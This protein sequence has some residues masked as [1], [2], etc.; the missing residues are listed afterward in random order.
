MIHH[1]NKQLYEKS[2][3]LLLIRVGAGSVFFMHGIGKLGSMA[4][5]TGFFIHL[6]LPGWTAPAIAFLETVGGLALVFGIFTRVAALL[7][8]IEML[9]AIFLTGFTKG[10]WSQHELEALLMAVSFG[11]VYTGSG[12][13]SLW[14]WDP[15]I[16]R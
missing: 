14:H 7:L 11:L 1:L 2:L 4:M 6:G 16:D 10:G 8:G 9:V 12:K 3:G 15:K 13:W 5:I